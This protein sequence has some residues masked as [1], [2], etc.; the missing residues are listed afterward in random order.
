MTKD[1]TIILDRSGSMR[2][3]KPYVILEFNR[4][5]SE[6]Q[7]SKLKSRFNLIQFSDTAEWTF[8]DLKAEDVQLL[9]ESKY[10]TNG[11]TALYDTIGETLNQKIQFIESKKK[12]RSVTVAIITDG[13]ENS[14][15]EYSQKIIR[16]LVTKCQD[17]L[18][19]KILFFGANQDSVLEGSQFGLDKTFCTDIKFSKRGMQTAFQSIKSEVI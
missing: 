9:D 1:I 19:W 8:T 6:F 5:I 11:S 7:T 18:H 2:Q 4:F 3:I 13:R 10:I 15:V 14:S 17:H 16:D 12:P